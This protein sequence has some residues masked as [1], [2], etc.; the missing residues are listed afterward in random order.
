MLTAE[1]EKAIQS[2]INNRTHGA[3]QLATWVLDA[4]DAEIARCRGAITT[5]SQNNNNNQQE[6][7]EEQGPKLLNSLRNFG[8]HLATC[9][10]SMAPLAN[11]VAE[12]LYSTHCSLHNWA[13]PFECTRDEVCI[14]A[15]KGVAEVRARLAANSEQLLTNAQEILQD[16][17]TIL[18]ISK[19]SSVLAAVETALR[20]GKRVR[21]I[22]CESRP[23]C[24]GVAVAESWAAAGADVTVITDAQA[25]VFMPQA[26]IVLV[27]ADAIDEKGVHNKAG[28]HLLALAA[29]AANVP[30]YALADSSKLSPGSLT[31]LAHPG[32][33]LVEDLGE[34]KS[35]DEVIWGWGGATVR[36]QVA[37]R[38]VYFEATPLHL[39]TSVVTE[40]GV[41][42][43]EGI[44]KEID[45]IED[46]YITAFQLQV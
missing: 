24:E 35:A 14:A 41:L 46:M 39:I 10:P 23:L 11:T 7:D 32:K 27:G 20:Q 4:F 5:S 28:T 44:K 34:E 2:V 12:V 42:D 40:K 30:F 16:G 13:G 22:V 37:V 1:Q 9:R 26:D 31:D 18:T 29:K 45:R 21:A 25:A 3:A 43:V 36:N 19:S 33:A 8:Y 38:N 17:M 6:D 15:S